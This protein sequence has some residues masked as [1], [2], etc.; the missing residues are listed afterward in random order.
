M[1]LFEFNE[2]DINE[3]YRYLF[4]GNI[5]G[6]KCLWDDEEYKYSLWDCG[7][8]Y[9][10]VQRRKTDRKITRVDGLT[11]EDD[12]INLFLDFINEHKD[13]EIPD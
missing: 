2:L 11:Q 5:I 8:F 9:A 4:S 12:R 13:D 1:T 7:T 10:E 3:R 6:F